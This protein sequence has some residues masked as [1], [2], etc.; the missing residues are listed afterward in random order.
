MRQ[1]VIGISVA[2][3]AVLALAGAAVAARPNSGL[4]LVVVPDDDLSALAAAEPWYGGQVTFEVWTSQTDR[5]FVNVRCY[6]GD[7]W[8]YDGWHGFFESYV[9]DPVYT[10]ASLVWT[11]G[12]ADCTANLVMWTKSARLKTLATMSFHVSE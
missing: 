3:I 8:V 1:S 2:L 9:P 10:L 6:Q 7:R 11:R 5:P 4:N 12:E